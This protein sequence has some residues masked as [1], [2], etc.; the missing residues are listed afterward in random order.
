MSGAKS[1]R[2]LGQAA[3]RAVEL[4]AERW[5]LMEVL[6]RVQADARS[7]EAGAVSLERECSVLQATL[8]R[9][10]LRDVQI[11][12]EMSELERQAAAVRLQTAATV[13]RCDALAHEA[14]SLE[15]ALHDEQR[16]V[17][18]AQTRLGGAIERVTRLDYKL[19]F[20]PGTGSLPRR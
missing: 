18:A 10:A 4:E 6:E 9:E 15:R 11:A 20:S 8:D 16:D 19:R 14:E 17:S 13:R 2:Q 12:K 3:E 5:A 1:Y 7:A